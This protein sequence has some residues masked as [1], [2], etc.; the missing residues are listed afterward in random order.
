[1]EESQSFI[2]EESSEEESA[3]GSGNESDQVSALENSKLV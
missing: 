2:F 1:M 3:E